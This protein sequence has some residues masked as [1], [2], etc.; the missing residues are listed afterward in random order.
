MKPQHWILP[1]LIVVLVSACLVYWPGL[2]GGFLFDDFVNLDAI[3]ATG[4]VDNWPTFWRYITSGTADPTGRPMALLSF[5]LDARDWPAA[6]AP[7]LRTNLLIH[8]LNGALLFVLLHSLGRWLQWSNQIAQASALLACGLWLLH[9]LLVSTTLYA[10]QREAMLPATFT[11]LGLISY[12]HGRATYAQGKSK[13]GLGWMVM[14]MVGGT[15][16]AT[17]CK[18][19]G[20]LLP[21]LA[22]VLE[23]TVLRHPGSIHPDLSEPRLRVV[24]STLLLLPSVVVLVYLASFVPALTSPLVGRPWTI[25]ER[26]LTEPRVLLDYLQLL[27]IPRSVSTGLYNDAYVASTGLFQPWDTLPTLL[28]ILALPV[29]AFRIRNRFPALSAAVLFY[30]TGQLL[31]STVVP[32]EL[33]FEHRN[34][35]PAMLFFWPLAHVICASSR[36]RLQ[37]IAVAV[38]LLSLFAVTTYQRAELWG[39]PRQL[40][41]LWAT[42]NPDSSRAQA[43]VAM[44]DTSAGSPEQALN[45]LRPLWRQRPYDLQ[46]A[47]NYVNAACAWRGLSES[48]S[49]ALARALRHTDVGIQLI[50]RWM[51]NAIELGA[52]GNCPGLTLHDIELWLAAALENPA[53]NNVQ[54]RG[55]DIEPLLAQLAIRK[56]QPEAALQHFNRSLAAFTT[57]DVAA[58]QASIL[59]SNG[60]FKEALAHL[61]TYE[62]LKAQVRPPGQGMP[63]LHAKVLQ[64]QDYWPREMSILRAKLHAEINAGATP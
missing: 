40:A 61:D 47:F 26:L 4:P 23:V 6:S 28:L 21:A 11:L 25:A 62:R 59:A 49:Q 19:N 16:L 55:Q 39:N 20:V 54:T 31:E 17:L 15:L 2:T 46:L 48:E 22:L 38:T 41:A 42:Q 58:R 35:L 5:L 9:P 10:V 8:L 3:G 14:G 43:T 27:V 45:R 33:Y 18:A 32:L 44:L 63:R 51:T 57:P 29:L 56:Q 13:A 24:R 7:F 37:R 64:W 12:V 50:H 34:Y 53:V 30:F 1:G 36:P 60:Y 52:A